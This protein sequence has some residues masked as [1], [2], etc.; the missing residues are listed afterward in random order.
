MPIFFNRCLNSWTLVDGP[1]AFYWRMR[2]ADWLTRFAG[3]E[4]NLLVFNGPCR[5]CGGVVVQ[6]LQI[7][8]FLARSAAAASLVRPEQEQWNRVWQLLQV[9]GSV[10]QAMVRLQLPQD[11]CAGLFGS[12]CCIW[13][14]GRPATISERRFGWR[15]CRHNHLPWR[16]ERSLHLLAEWER[17]GQSG[18]AH[19]RGLV[20]GWIG[21]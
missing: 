3:S 21:H 4:T 15:C 8:L 12:C 10:L 1:S 2:R 5:S 14:I 17:R 20:P 11:R 6:S 9:R 19:V 16:A 18:L 7:Q 13:A